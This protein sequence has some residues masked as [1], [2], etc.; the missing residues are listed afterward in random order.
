MSETTLQALS[1][2]EQSTI[3]EALLRL[4]GEYEDFPSE[5][6]TKDIFWNFLKPNRSIGIFSMPG[7]VYL[8]RYVSGSFRAQ[9]PFSV[10]Y[11]TK[12]TNN[13]SRIEKQSVLDELGEWLESVTYP[14][15]SDNR[16]I[17]KIERTASSQLIGVDA[18]GNELYQC[19][20]VLTYSKF[21]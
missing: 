17:D 11:T 9:F 18:D 7:A 13:K 8:R 14:A 1:V 5:I 20:M 2:T 19:N 21:N 3:S 15:L 4:I 16:T 10:R 6:S 12:P